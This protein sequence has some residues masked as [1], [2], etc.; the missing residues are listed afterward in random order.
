M[1][2]ESSRLVAVRGLLPGVRVVARHFFA[3]RATGPSVG[4]IGE[5]VGG[6]GRGSVSGCSVELRRVGLVAC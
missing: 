6:H 1:G 4:S 5:M 3:G 2:A